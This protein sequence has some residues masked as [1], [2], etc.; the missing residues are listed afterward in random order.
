MTCEWLGCLTYLTKDE[1]VE[2]GAHVDGAG[3]GVLC[4]AVEHVEDVLADVVA[5][6]DGY[7]VA[8]DHALV[9]GERR[10]GQ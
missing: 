2:Q 10:M 1:G 8:D 7:G 4:K 6:V 9:A 3:L 5:A